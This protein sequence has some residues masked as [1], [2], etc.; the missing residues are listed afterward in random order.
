MLNDKLTVDAGASYIIQDDRNMTNQGVYG[1]PLVTAYLYPRGNSIDDLKMFERW[2]TQRNLY[3]QNWNDLASEFVGQNPYWINY[4]NVRTNRKYRYMLNLG[5]SYKLTDY[6]SLAAR[7]RV[8]NATNTFEK[9]YY[10]STNKTLAG[11]NGQYALV[12]TDDK[13]TYGDVMMTFDKR[14][15]QDRLSVNANLGAIISDVKQATTTRP[16]LSS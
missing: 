16:S 7:I 3:V 11:E 15:F 14:F 12:K 5:A 6:L 9:K 1:N 10:A 13:Q 8:D 4:R 2:D